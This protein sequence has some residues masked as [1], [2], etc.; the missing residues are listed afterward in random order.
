MNERNGN[1]D[2]YQVC[3]HRSKKCMCFYGC[4]TEMSSEVAVEDRPLKWNTNELVQA[5]LSILSNYELR[6]Q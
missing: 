5:K 2:K 6:P 4:L 3:F 1:A